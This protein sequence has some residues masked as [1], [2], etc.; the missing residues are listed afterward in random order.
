MSSKSTGKFQT[1]GVLFKAFVKAVGIDV[2]SAVIL[3]G[4]AAFPN[5]PDSPPSPKV[6]VLMEAGE[7]EF[8][9]KVPMVACTEQTCSGRH[10]SAL[11]E[12]S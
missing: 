10:R 12:S 1:P 7:W 4:E 6:Q 11:W 9:E 3:L 8:K 5:G 2:Q